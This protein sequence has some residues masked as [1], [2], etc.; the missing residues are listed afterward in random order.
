MSKSSKI[1]VMLSS[2]CDD[3]FPAGSKTTLSVIRREIKSEIEAMEVAGRKAFEVW[4]NDDAAPGSGT[5]DS[6]D[7]CIQAVKDCDVLLI[8]CNGNAGWAKTGGSVG[9]C[10]AEMMTGLSIAPA[11]V[12]LIALTNI[13]LKR[14]EAGIRNARFQQEI[15]KQS[16]FRGGEVKTKEELTQRV[17]EALHDAI[18]GLVQAGV[19]DAAKGKFHSGAALD[20]SRLDYAAREHEMA[21]VLREAI[22]SRSGSKDEK[23]QILAKFDGRDVL[24]KLHAI[25]AALSVPA[26]R[27][28]VGQPFLRDHESAPALTGKRG[29][30]VHVIACHKTATE[31]QAAKLLGF[32]DAT[33]VSAP[34]GVFAADPIQ[35][36]Q[37]SFIT[38]CRDE[39]NTRHGLDRFLE[40]LEQTGEDKLLADRAQARARI[41]NAVAK[42]VKND[43]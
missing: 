8:I 38:N 6:W 12:R 35:K 40:W 26:A 36:V 27:E 3:A 34:F 24:V 22:L 42:E 30:P 18:V 16:L 11:K 41:V 15:A 14:D 1:R 17:K 31:T 2:R 7:T 39:S 19:R 37:F 43:R 33:L 13:L 29:G 32:T 9:I 5:W 25:P 23:G 28:R 20:W 21:R 4:I 10:H